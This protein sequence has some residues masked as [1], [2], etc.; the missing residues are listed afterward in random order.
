MRQQEG[1]VTQ[2]HKRIIDPTLC[3]HIYIYVYTC[4]YIYTHI[5]TAFFFSLSVYTHIYI[6]AG[7]RAHIPIFKFLLTHWEGRETGWSYSPLLP[8]YIPCISLSCSVHSKRREDKKGEEKR[9]YSS[10]RDP[11][12]PFRMCTWSR[13]GEREN[14]NRRR[15]ER[16]V[17]GVNEEWLDRSSA[18]PCL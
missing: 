1:E 12:H 4:V 10:D 2:K 13:E 18:V 11:Y 6:E 16:T 9:K 15:E 3:W 17:G 8:L 14:E 5:H 7:W